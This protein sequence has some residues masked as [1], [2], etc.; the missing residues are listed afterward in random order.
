M[1]TKKGT[2]EDKKR[3]LEEQFSSST[4]TDKDWLMWRKAKRDGRLTE[5]RK[6]LRSSAYRKMK[7]VE[8]NMQDKQ[9]EKQ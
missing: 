7:K 4:M 2:K 1:E 5:H 9:R 6:M 3:T 8:A